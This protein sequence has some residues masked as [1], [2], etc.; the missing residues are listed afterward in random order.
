MPY[1][2]VLLVAEKATLQAKIEEE[3]AA[4]QYPPW[5]KFDMYTNNY[6]IVVTSWK[7]QIMTWGLLR[8]VLISFLLLLLYILFLD[9]CDD[10]EKE[11][12]AI[13]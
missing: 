8:G 13:K 3:A 4:R 9:W 6:Q 11:E 2:V 7:V 10:I 1:R 5:C 12:D